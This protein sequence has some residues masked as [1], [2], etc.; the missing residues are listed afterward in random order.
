MK[1]ASEHPTDR[2]TVRFSE[3]GSYFTIFDRSLFE[4]CVLPRV[5]RAKCIYLLILLFFSCMYMCKL[6]LE[7]IFTLLNYFLPL[8]K[9]GEPGGYTSFR[10]HGCWSSQTTCP[11]PLHVCVALSAQQLSQLHETT[12]CLR[13]QICNFE[14]YFACC[15]LPTPSVL[16]R[17]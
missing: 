1:S 15:E 11:I 9:L 6:S 13:V 14:R 10:V 7:T 2:A 12:E 16:A 5:R 3:D 4:K 8:E 17:S